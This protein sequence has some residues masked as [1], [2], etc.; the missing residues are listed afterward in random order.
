[1]MISNQQDIS[2][3]LEHGAK[4]EAVKLQKLTTVSFQLVLTFSIWKEESDGQAKTD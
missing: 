3:L 1:M 4:L 2:T